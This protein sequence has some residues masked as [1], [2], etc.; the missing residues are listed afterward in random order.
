MT[1]ELLFALG[2]G[3]IAASVALALVLAL[4]VPARRRLGA[5]FAY[6]LWL[7]V[8]VAA[9]A[10]FLPAPVR[11][12][13]SA[14]PLAP[15]APPL[16][17]PI[18]LPA[19]MAEAAID[20]PPYLLALWIAGTLA[21]VAIFVQQQRRYVKNLGAL[22]ASDGGALRAQAT[23]GCPAL[24]GALRPRIVVPNDFE[25]R[26]TPRERELVLAHER[27]H[28]VRGD[29]QINA[30]AALLRCLNWFNPLFHFAASRFRFDQEI[31]CDAAVMS[32]F[33]EARRS[34]ADAMLKAQL[35]GESRQE[36]RLPAGCHWPTSH[37]LKERI[38][39]L[40][41]PIPS[42]PR[43]A[44]ASAVLVALASTAGYTSWAA[45]PQKTAATAEAATTAEPMAVAQATFVRTDFVVTI[46]G[47]RV[48][49][50]GKTDAGKNPSDGGHWRAE[51]NNTNDGVVVNGGR[52][53]LSVLNRAG[54][55]WDA[56]VSK[57]GDSWQIVGVSEPRAD[58]TIAFNAKVLHN[59]VVVSMP[60]LI[61][62]DGTATAFG[63]NDGP[64]KGFKLD[65]TLRKVDGAIA[66]KLSGGVGPDSAVTENLSYRRMYPPKYPAEAV[67][68][69]IS[70]KVMLRVAVD[71]NGTPTSAEVKSVEPPQSARVLADAAVATAMQWRFNPA[72]ENG[73]LVAGE[74]LVPV[75]FVLSDTESSKPLAPVAAEPGDAGVSYRKM[76]PPVYPKEMIAAK[77][78]G[79]LYVRAHVDAEGKVSDA[80]VD[81]A[82]PP[83]ALA[84]KDSALAAIKGWQFNPPMQNGRAVESEVLVPMKYRIEGETPS[85][86]D[87]VAPVYP[88]SVRALESI[89]ITGAKS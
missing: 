43:R 2:R 74:I 61:V 33:P 50:T 1:H 19:A 28:L 6:R 65:F 71:E 73:R 17:A 38:A 47:E 51:L 3:A 63:I 34:Y 31:A 14:V 60:S 4:R 39:M 21:L 77:I 54:Q 49:D 32:R 20:W 5:A 29:A 64:A 75:N 83:I 85:T 68:N 11:P 89:Q 24:V 56:T 9:L 8:P 84:L 18:E 59:Q 76:R 12:L 15:S 36:L 45:Q 66:R 58:G 79:T 10:S 26:Y 35:V 72:V 86:V 37:P 52:S 57:G 42:A 48:L 46:D 25:S 87:Y 69:H 62:N 81:Q 67:R 16:S 82:T 70:G 30:L 40:K 22:S 88:E 41:F 23:A 80:Y 27:T 44:L 13:A 55:P 7:L 78:S 53:G